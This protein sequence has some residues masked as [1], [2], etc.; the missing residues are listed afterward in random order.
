M[1]HY[2]MNILYIL[3]VHVM[4]LTVKMDG[5]DKILRLELQRVCRYKL[6]LFLE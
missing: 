4:M 2:G 5:Y 1:V 3:N 6:L